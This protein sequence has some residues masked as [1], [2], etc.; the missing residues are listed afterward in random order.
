MAH[1]VRLSTIARHDIP[2]AFA[3]LGDRRTGPAGRNIECC[4]Q[5]PAEGGQREPVGTI[6]A[7]T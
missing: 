2:I 1:G 5:G 4:V 3:L 7:G 6:R